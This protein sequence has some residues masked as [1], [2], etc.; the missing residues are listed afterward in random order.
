[1]QAY[2]THMCLEG[3]IYEG[4]IQELSLQRAT[5]DRC[6]CRQTCGSC[7][8]CEGSRTWGKKGE[9][10]K[11]DGKEGERKSRYEQVAPVNELCAER[12]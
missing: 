10:E 12:S 6:N 7:D 8:S 9:N 5:A 2:N 1:M 4:K 11:R 3:I